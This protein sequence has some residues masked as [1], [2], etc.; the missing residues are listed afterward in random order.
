ML[1]I[2]EIYGSVY[3]CFVTIIS[4]ATVLLVLSVRNDGY[5]ETIGRCRRANI[6]QSRVEIHQCVSIL[7]LE[8]QTVLS[9]LW[10]VPPPPKKKRQN[11]PL[12]LTPFP[13]SFEWKIICDF[14]HLSFHRWEHSLT[15]INTPFST[16]CENGPWPPSSTHLPFFHRL[17]L[18]FVF[19]VEQPKHILEHSN[20]AAKKVEK[21][22]HSMEPIP[23]RASIGHWLG[24][25]DCQSEAPLDWLPQL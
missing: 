13:S 4:N 1:E 7:Q 15:N 23:S 6:K 10:K 12:R 9:N 19:L 3:R 11:W 18:T 17:V 24:F 20:I 25:N 5:L 16:L 8:T 21:E 14:Y 22:R 2:C